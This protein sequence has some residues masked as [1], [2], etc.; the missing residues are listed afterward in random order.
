MSI[1][2]IE[3]AGVTKKYGEFVAVRDLDLRVPLGSTYALL[4][5]NGA[6]KTTTIRMILR[7]IEESTGQVRVFG[8]PVDRSVLD[9]VGYLPEERGVYKKMS[10]RRLLTFLAELKGVKPRDS[11]G[12]I[13]QWLE[14]LEL[15]DR[16][17]ARVE[18]LSKG[19]QQKIQFIA[20]ILHEPEIVILDEPFSGLDPINQGVLRE[21]IGELRAL[22]RTILFSTHIIEHAE[23][24]CDHVC[25]IAR[26]SQVV[27]GTL[28]DVKQRHGERY[29]ALAVDGG[30]DPLPVLSRSTLVDSVRNE[31]GGAGTG[32]GPHLIR[33]RDTADP[34]ELLQELV[35]ER[36]RIRRFE[37]VEPSLE[38]IFIERVGLSSDVALTEQEVVHV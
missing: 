33:L 4:G 31:A 30:Q 23:R 10:V 3:L 35:T 2:A 21:I 16:R 32:A 17:D 37:V 13:D 15:A 1:A 20:T 8:Q 14:R 29:I 24:I 19:M 27:N 28:A 25:I 9:R 11:R 7:I 36:V 26:G 5:P 6:G 12:R 38:Q 22:G 34:H 18:E